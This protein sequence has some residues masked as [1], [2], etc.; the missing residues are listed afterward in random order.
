MQAGT[1][2]N[3]PRSR[4]SPSPRAACPGRQA[5]TVIAS[6]STTQ[7]A[8]RAAP[9]RTP[10]AP[11]TPSLCPTSTSVLFCEWS[12]RTISALTDRPPS[13]SLFL[14]MMPPSLSFWLPKLPHF[15]PELADH[16]VSFLHNDVASL[17]NCTL[18]S[19]AWLGPS[20]RQLFDGL[21]IIVRKD[22]RDVVSFT[23]RLAS[24]PGT[25]IGRHVRRL[26]LDDMPMNKRTMKDRFPMNG[27][28]MSAIMGYFPHLQSL[29]LKS[30]VYSPLPPDVKLNVPISP[31]KPHMQTIILHVLSGENPNLV[32]SCLLD[33]LSAFSEIGTLEILP[34]M[35]QTRFGMS[36]DEVGE[37]PMP[38]MPTIHKLRICFPYLA[39]G[40]FHGPVVRAFA[41]TRP[42]TLSVRACATD[43]H[44]RAVGDVLAGSAATLK[45]FEFEFFSWQ[46]MRSVRGT[47][48][49]NVV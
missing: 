39:N 12:M 37:L 27:E 32:S 35:E 38:E 9:P 30:L 24:S 33:C 46:M 20:R 17:S 34:H 45:N 22:G 10:Q 6:T 43:G 40:V 8:T 29:E 26:C 41:N 21:N 23:S 1:P 36:C 15:P 18:V 14:A 7:V 2:R 19:R 44:F 13:D 5:P 31:N 28:T 49:G 48:H 4:A 47:T 11:S 3:P 42:T 16:I 25:G